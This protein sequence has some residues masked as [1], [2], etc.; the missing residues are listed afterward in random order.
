[1]IKYNK[2]REIALLKINRSNYVYINNNKKHQFVGYETTNHP[3]T[4]SQFILRYSMPHDCEEPLR[5]F[6]PFLR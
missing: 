3:N 1:M 4:L 5:D 6:S 2:A